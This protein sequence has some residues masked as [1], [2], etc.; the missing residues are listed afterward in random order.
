MAELEARDVF[1]VQSFLWAFWLLFFALGDFF[2][3]E[4]HFI[5]QDGLILMILLSQHLECWDYKHEPTT[6]KRM[7]K[8]EILK[9][10]CP[11]G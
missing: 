11:Y 6:S 2:P 5:A 7:A 8:C 4:S 1:F 3:P 10:K 9:N